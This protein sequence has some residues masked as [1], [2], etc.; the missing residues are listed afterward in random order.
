[1]KTFDKAFHSRIH[2]SVRYHDFMPIARRKIWISF[3]KKVVAKGQDGIGVSDEEVDDLSE[4]AVN[5]RQIK[6][7]V[8]T[9]SILSTSKNESLGYAHLVQV[10]NMMAQFEVNRNEMI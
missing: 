6:N 9:A 1:M 5:G 2:L 10:L 7:V 8:K 3:L 4:R